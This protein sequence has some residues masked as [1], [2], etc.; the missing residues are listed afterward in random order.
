MV[1]V[2]TCGSR[3]YLSDM[4][5]VESDDCADSHHSYVDLS[6]LRSLG[7][8]SRMRRLLNSFRGIR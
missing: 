3:L 2:F 6:K 5:W 8:P 1:L 7:Q 4:S